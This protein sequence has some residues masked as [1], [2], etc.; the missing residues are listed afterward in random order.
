MPFES[1]NTIRLPIDKIFLGRII[2]QIVKH[3]GPIEIKALKVVKSKG[4][5]IVL[6]VEY[7]L[8]NGHHETV[9]VKQTSTD[10]ITAEY[11]ALKDVWERIDRLR[12]VQ[13]PQP[14]Y[15]SPEDN[16]LITSA[17]Q[18][19]TLDQMFFGK[20]FS[21]FKANRNSL[22]R[23]AY[24]CGRGL[25][26]IQ[27]L[28]GISNATADF[29]YIVALIKKNIEGMN[30]ISVEMEKQLFLTL[31]T[32][33]EKNADK[34]IPLAFPHGDLK[35]QNIVILADDKV[36]FLDWGYLPKTLLPIYSDLASFCISVELR[37]SFNLFGL[38]TNVR[39]HCLNG[40]F[41]NNPR[42]IDPL[43]FSFFCIKSITSMGLDMLK[44]HN[45][46]SSRKVGYW[47]IKK[48]LKHECEKLE[49]LLQ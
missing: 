43:L 14:L 12:F 4:D 31:H 13:V 48:A 36:G 37:M 28:L 47:L 46:P 30:C 42:R 25:Y 21:V 49:H 7:T 35:P 34:D 15:C 16:I 20:T 8:N 33:I 40:Y 17:L 38:A 32:V 2:D 11:L 10:K 44:R 5:S 24:A 22:Y 41:H 23:M 19:K 29:S 1:M 27:N 18:G 26:E 45:T 6:K 3:A 9:Y 39:G